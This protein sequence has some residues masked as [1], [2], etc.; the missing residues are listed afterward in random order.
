MPLKNATAIVIQALEYGESDKIVTFFTLEAGKLKGIAKGARRS[1]KRFSNCLDLFCH[2]QIQFFEKEDR[3]LTRVD[4]CDGIEFFPAL[5]DDI[6]K[7][8]YACYFVELVDALLGEG[9]VNRGVFE[10]LRSFLSTLNA[11]APKEEMARIF[12]VRLLSLVGYRPHLDGCVNCLKSVDEMEQIFFVPARG[13]IL[14]NRCCRAE[15]RAFPVS[16][17][18]VKLL[19][20]SADTELGKIHRL[21]FSP[22]AVRESR[23]ILASFIQYHLSKPL[24]SLRFLESVKAG[25]SP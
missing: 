13:G 5:S 20:K 17:G 21:R 6:L 1:R 9:E 12:E 24:K 7:T 18:T 2:V 15:D 8:S 25:V 22:G 14:C 16:R 3:A 23:D 19:A 10:L 4:Q 11:E